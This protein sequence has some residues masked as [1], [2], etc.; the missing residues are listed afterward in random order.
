MPLILPGNVASA[1]ADAGY[2]VANS[3]RFNDGDSAYMTLADSDPVVNQ[4]KATFSFW[5]KR[6][7]LGSYQVIYQHILEADSGAHESQIKFRDTDI[8]EWHA[9]N[10]DIAAPHW[11]ALYKTNAVFRDC[12]A[13][14]HFVVALDSSQASAGDRVKIYVNGE[15]ITSF[16]TETQ[17]AQDANLMIDG[18][19]GYISRIG[20]TDVPDNHFD[21][22][23]AEFFYI[24][25]QQ[26]TPT[27]FGEYDEDSPTIWKPKD[28]K[29]DLTFG[30]NG[31]YL[32]YSDSADLGADSSGNSNDFTSTN[33]AATDQATDTPTNNFCTLNPITNRPAANGIIAEGNLQYTC[34][35]GDSSIY[36]TIAIPPGMKVY[37]EVKLV[38]NGNQNAI[39]IH[40]LYDGGDGAFCKGGSEAGTY[41]Y[42]VRGGSTVTQY[43]NDGSMQNT[44]IS[45]YADGTIIGVA[46]DNENG[47]IHYSADGTYIN[48]SDPTDNDPVALV[49]GFGGASEQYLHFSTDTPNDTVINQFNF[50]SPPY[51]ESGGETDGNG[52]GNF[53]YAVPNGYYVL[54]S[55]NLA[56]FG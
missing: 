47:Q 31:F 44:A 17:P 53:A 11:V 10:G 49:T 32:S 28:C 35:T 43:Y 30:T 21:G 8:L 9:Y 18:G 52:Y 16:G 36:G 4:K 20:A 23:L 45:N 7:T 13:W 55:K 27:S 24:D 6:G 26:L 3:C 25:N 40:N 51:S 22:Y 19:D 14:Y 50:G 5:L 37:F 56:E 15:Q 54:C 33:L 12:S 2:T 34:Q 1:T 46:I 48:S 42:K 38:A 29:D 39:G 41:S